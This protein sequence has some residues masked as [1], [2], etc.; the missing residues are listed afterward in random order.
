[1]A[2][3]RRGVSASFPWERPLG[4]RPLGDGTA[5]F[6]VWAPRAESIGLRIGRR[7]HALDDAGYGVYET[8]VEA[9]ASNQYWYVVDGRRLPDPCSRSQPKGLRGPSSVLDITPAERSAAPGSAELVIYE[10]HVGTFTAEGT[11]E[12]AAAHLAE[13][14]EIGVTAIEL[15]PV[16]EFPG[17]HGWGYDGVYISAPHSAYGG[18][19]GLAKLV[20][21][22]HEHGLE[23]I[24]DVVYNHVGASGV[25]ALE[26]FGPYFTTQYETP[27]GQAINFDGAD[28]DPVREW[29]LQSAEGWIRD[30]NID[31]LRLDAIHSIYDSSADHIVAEIVRRVHSVRD[32]AWVIA[33]SGLNDPRVM[34]T[35]ELGGYGCNAAWADD[36]HHALRTVLTS[37]RDGYYAEFGRVSQL[38]KAFHRPHV[39]DGDYSEFRRRRFGAP[40]DD[41]PPRRFVVFSQNHDQVGNRAFGDRL[42]AAVRPLAAFCTLLAPFVPMLFMGEEYG[43]PA[44][45]QFF[46]DHIDK[47]IADATR[48]G[49]RREFAAFAE[50]EEDI[51]DPQDPATFERSKLTRERDPRLAELYARLLVERRRLPPGDAD[52]IE[53]DEEQRW[54][55]VQRG[56]FEILCN[57][58]DEP[59]R[60]P[61]EGTSVELSTHEP[62][63]P[64][65]GWAEL[66]PMSGALVR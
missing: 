13:L 62:P 4:A 28:S 57:F 66:T 58:S 16:A 22:A 50:F 47:R 60:V 7:E 5:E 36:F 24:L 48:E 31:G 54:L 52:T 3:T 37:E 14:A 21:A 35:P 10:L 23:V 56:P 15:M 65:D 53:F 63:Q 17:H 1:M 18:P 59:R 42:S 27:W 26:R 32:D 51:P 43:E 2:R 61:C 25:N 11:F 33:E 40:A 45:F 20:A 49:R 19:T 29:V 34:R 64:S 39:H 9:Q 8:V 46:S 30:Y 12:A 41:V 44:P 6:R 38:A 55:R